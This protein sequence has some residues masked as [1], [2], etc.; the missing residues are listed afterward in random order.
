MVKYLGDL[1][2][3]GVHSLLFNINVTN[4]YDKF[5]NSEK[6]IYSA[7]IDVL[8]RV[9]ALRK[10][11]KYREKNYMHVYEDE[12]E[13]I[14]DTTFILSSLMDNELHPE[15]N[16]IAYYIPNLDSNDK[17]FNIEEL[18]DETEINNITNIIPILKSI[19][20]KRYIIKRSNLDYIR[21]FILNKEKMFIYPPSP[22]NITQQFFF[23]QNISDCSNQF[24]A[25]DPFPL[26]Y[27]NYLQKNYSKYNYSDHNANNSMSMVIE[28]VDKKS[29]FGSVC[30][31]M[32][33]MPDE[34][35]PSFMCLGLDFANIFRSFSFN[36]IEK[37]EFG[38]FTQVDKTLV[39]ITSINE[40][41]YD[42]IYNHFSDRTK[43]RHPLLFWKIKI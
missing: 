10:F 39:Y 22:Y 36:N 41:I 33:Y 34:K 2:L 12:F 13:N 6:K 18:L 29:T 21:F 27:Y 19:Y 11:S 26:C 24:A 37:Y 5:D 4:D 15:L 7:T 20:V 35:D 28:K 38:L 30:I 16:Y 31:K 14:T 43:R 3:I 17:R 1:K 25:C 42:S 40:D 32:K 9:G 8:S 23:G